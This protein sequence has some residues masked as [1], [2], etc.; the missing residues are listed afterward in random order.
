MFFN[1]IFKS[2]KKEYRNKLNFDISKGV[3]DEKVINIAMNI[4]KKE[5]PE[6]YQI[7]IEDRNI[8]MSKRLLELRKKHSGNIIAVIGAGHVEGM[9]SIINK[10]INHETKLN[11]LLGKNNLNVFTFESNIE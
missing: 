7:L 11:K 9:Y 1:L 4:F 8:Y 3:P 10:K 2:F 5:V 6:L